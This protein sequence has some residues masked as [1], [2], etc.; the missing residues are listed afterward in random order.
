MLKSGWSTLPRNCKTVNLRSNTKTCL[1]LHSYFLHT[2]RT[3]FHMLGHDLV[4]D[5]VWVETTEEVL[6]ISMDLAYMCVKP[7]MR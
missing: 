2:C 5:P 3:M 4:L 6:Q 7:Q 1:Q